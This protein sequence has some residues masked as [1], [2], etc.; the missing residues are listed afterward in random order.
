MA[1]LIASTMGDEPSASST[2]RSSL[3]KLT[4]SVLTPR[5]RPPLSSKLIGALVSA[6]EQQ[7]V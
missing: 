6:C 5:A 4:S 2:V 1:P 3:V 7:A